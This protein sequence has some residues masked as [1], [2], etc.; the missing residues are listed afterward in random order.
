[1]FYTWTSCEFF[2]GCASELEEISAEPY[3]LYVGLMAAL[4]DYLLYRVF[5]VAFL[6]LAQPHQREASSS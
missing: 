5:F 3:L 2:L 1:M 6:V 4:G